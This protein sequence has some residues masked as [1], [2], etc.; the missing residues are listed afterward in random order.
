MK[1][2][3]VLVALSVVIALIIVA[4]TAWSGHAAPI[5]PTPPTD[6]AAPG[7]DVGGLS[8]QINGPDGTPSFSIVTLLGITLLSV[9]PALLLMMTSFTKIFVVLAHDPQRARA[10]VDPAEPGARRTRPVPVACSSWRRCCR[11][12]NDQ[13][14][15]ALPRRQ[16]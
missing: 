5:D 1:R 11:R 9:A 14:R 2:V 4:L 8:V 7:G 13:R 10:A 16:R 3:A 15:A 6:P 12:V